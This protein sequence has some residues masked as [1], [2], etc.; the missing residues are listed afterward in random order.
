MK[1][2]VCEICGSQKILKKDGVFCCQ[3]CGM[4][5]SLEDARSLLQETESSDEA[6]AI[7]LNLKMAKSGADKYEAI[8]MLGCWLRC[9]SVF[10]NANFWLDGSIP[11]YDK[12][13]FIT[14]EFVS[15]VVNI[16]KLTIPNLQPK[17]FYEADFS[18]GRY[19]NIYGG[20]SLE[21]IAKTKLKKDSR[22]F[23]TL[24]AIDR[25][26]YST[27]TYTFGGEEIRNVFYSTDGQ[28]SEPIGKRLLVDPFDYL[29]YLAIGEKTY[30]A[31]L[32]CPKG[33]FGTQ[34]VDSTDTFGL[35]ET[36]SVLRAYMKEFEERHGELVSYY[37]KYFDAA[38][39][40]F[41]ETQKSIAELENTFFLPEKYR[42][43][44]TIAKLLDIFLEGR[45]DT[46][47][48]ALNLFEQ[49]S[50]MDLIVMGVA[51]I[52]NKLDVVGRKLDAVSYQLSR[53]NI[54]I[55]RLY[56][57]ASYMSEALTYI[58]LDTRWQLLDNMLG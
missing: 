57:Q 20:K 7:C 27:F 45:A 14:N 15:R 37:N 46:W 36:M 22:V 33:L 30:R 6:S 51:Q 39:S 26:S 23:K 43:S 9:I 28:Y 35:P 19:G 8:D 11:P 34:W 56:S 5:Y 1:K 17:D 13:S 3:E 40:I 54:G 18:H 58:A 32:L 53:I 49:E 31:K 24:L 47:K 50:R 55:D 29:A 41:K 48:E 38:V 4:Q 52:S 10:E 42:N 12:K 44:S 2:M 25:S 16:K 21:E